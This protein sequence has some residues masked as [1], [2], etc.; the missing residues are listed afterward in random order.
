MSSAWLCYHC[1]FV[2]ERPKTLVCQKCT[3]FRNSLSKPVNIETWKESDTSGKS[4]PEADTVIVIDSDSDNTEERISKKPSKWHV[5][6]HQETKFKY[7]INI[8]LMNGSYLRFLPVTKLTYVSGL[9]RAGYL[10]F[11]ELIQKDKLEKAMLSSYC[12]DMDWVDRLLPENKNVCYV[13]HR[14]G[15]FPNAVRSWFL[16]C[17]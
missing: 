17:A 3:K 12:A 14:K 16:C 8:E 13:L 7:K 15:S 10:S 9:P 2:N 11:Q 1:K 4:N 6:S 5:L